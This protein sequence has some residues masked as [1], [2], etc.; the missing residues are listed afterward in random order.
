MTEILALS[1][2][3]EFLFFYQQTFGWD[4]VCLSVMLGLLNTMMDLICPLGIYGFMS[5][6]QAQ[7]ALKSSL[8]CSIF[9]VSVHFGAHA[10]AEL[11]VFLLLVDET[12][13]FFF[14]KLKR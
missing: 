3:S 7:T 12:I 14:F 6:I 2:L 1:R 4:S 11:D 5:E 8:P 9:F 10:E 13:F